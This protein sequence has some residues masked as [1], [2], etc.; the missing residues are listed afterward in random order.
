M[1]EGPSSLGAADLSHGSELGDDLRDRVLITHLVYIEL[2][3]L[4]GAVKF[5]DHL[6]VL[7]LRDHR[8][9]EALL[10]EVVLGL[11]DD[12]GS[13]GPELGL[14]EFFVELEASCRLLLL[15]TLP[16]LL[17]NLDILRD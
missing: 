8:V 2:L 16:L 7:Q 17:R 12:V 13:V 1:V 3:E 4:D 11:L 10:Q 5:F 15:V 6:E 14:A 9:L